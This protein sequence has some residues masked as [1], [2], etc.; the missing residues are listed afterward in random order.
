LFHRKQ[1]TS[2]RIENNR[3][4][5]FPPS[6]YSSEK[7]KTVQTVYFAVR[8]DA[9]PSGGEDLAKRNALLFYLY[10]IPFPPI[11][12]RKGKKGEFQGRGGSHRKK[13]GCFPGNKIDGDAGGREKKKGK[14]E[15]RHQSVPSIGKGMRCLNWGRRDLRHG[16]NVAGLFLQEVEQFARRLRKRKRGIASRPPSTRTPREKLSTNHQRKRDRS[17]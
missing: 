11:R 17:H 6:P 16:E 1:D 12:R 2:L 13:R 10:L 5:A 9:W 7:K 8:K 4:K 14:A 3:G 15:E